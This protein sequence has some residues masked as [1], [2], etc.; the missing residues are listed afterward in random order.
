MRPPL[1]LVVFVVGAASLGAE[2]AAARLLAPYFGASTIIWANTIATVLVALSAGYALGGRL[3]DRAPRMSR[4]CQIVLAAAVLLGAVPFLSGPLLHV[5][6]T[7]IGSLSVGAFFGSLLAVLALVAVPVLLLGTVAPFAIRL[8]LERTE[9]SG[10]VSGRLYALSTAGSLVGTFLAAL[11]LI[12]FAG[13]H[14]TFLAFAL[15]LA[16]IAVPGLPRL[17]LIV[18]VLLA[19]LL[20]LPPGGVDLRIAG[21]GRVI[22]ETETQ[23]QYARVVEQPSGERWL[24]L[25]EGV[26][27]HSL[28]VPG[29]YLTGNYWDG[30]LVLPFTSRPL[31]PAR[32]AILGDAAGTT[33]RAYGHYFPRTVID[34]VELDGKLTDIGRRFF[35]LGSPRRL[36]TITAD[37]RPW[38]ASVSGRYDAVFLDAYRQPYIP[39]YLATREFF[40]LIRSHLRAGGLVIINVGHPA[41][42]AALERAISAT[43][44][45]VFPVV[46]RDPTEP[47][48]TLLLASASPLG[49]RGL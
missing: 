11:V 36:H 32:I 20:A 27:T 44:R 13:T 15:A 17:S 43:L 47:T 25:N 9:E 6:S 5:A 31:P 21:G 40:A 33:A 23:Y 46:L 14:R 3:A 39:F 28:Y 4:L 41:G 38:L 45:A 49:A 37:A 26:A 10:R 30:F 34:A 1:G 48:N 2:I 7:A 35:A 12:P 42:S 16:L 24:Q 8:S 22:Y 18:P 19:V 29:S